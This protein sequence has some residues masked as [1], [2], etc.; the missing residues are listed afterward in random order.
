MWFWRCVGRAFGHFLLGSRN[1]MVTAL[2]SCV[3]CYIG[4][5]CIHPYKFKLTM[6]TSSYLRWSEDKYA[7]IIHQNLKICIDF[8]CQII[9]VAYKLNITIKAWEHHTSISY[10]LFMPIGGKPRVNLHTWWRVVSKNDLR[11]LVVM[12]GSLKSMTK[13]NPHHFIKACWRDI[14]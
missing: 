4:N 10:S 1:F 13:R 7:K 14:M 11:C 3:K 5:T 9:K 12:V 8:E 2:G 6:A